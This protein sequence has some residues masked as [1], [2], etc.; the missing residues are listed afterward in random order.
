VISKSTGLANKSTKNKITTK[1][2]EQITEAM[3]FR[4]GIIYRNLQQA[5]IN[6]GL[7][8]K[9]ILQLNKMFA[10]SPITHHIQPGD[11]LEVLYHEYFLNDHRNHPGHI[12][13]AEIIG[14]NKDYKVVRFTTPHDKISYYK[15]NGQ[16]TKPKFNRIPLHYV[17][18]GSYFSLHRMDPIL[19]KVRPHLGVDF[20]AP[21]GTP[22]HSIGNGIV[23]FCGQ[24]RG[25]GNVI[26]V[27][28][29]NTY[30]SLYAHLRQFANHMK[31]DEHVKKGEV[32]GY[33]GMTGW[34][35]GPHLHYGVYKNGVAVNPLTVQ[36]PSSASIPEKYRHAF[37]NDEDHWFDEMQLFASADHI[38][39]KKK[40]EHKIAKR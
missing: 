5:A 26:I 13:A 37:F 25:Y 33:V 8:E 24:M 23:V 6:A 22:I 39:Q 19:H 3:R 40:N 29:N 20:D 31:D 28:Y 12:V 32:L 10:H 9:M 30:K 16:S 34:T 15:T 14:K 1:P 2:T 11:R 21:M 35:T 4:T 7:T 18:I 17:R 38:T 36:F 27:R